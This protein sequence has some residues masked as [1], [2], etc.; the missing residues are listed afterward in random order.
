MIFLYSRV[1]KQVGHMWPAMLFYVGHD[2]FAISVLPS[3][4]LHDKLSQFFVFL[5][6]DLRQ[7]SQTH[8]T[9][10]KCGHKWP[11]DHYEG[12]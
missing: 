5:D 12:K 2:T 11:Y 7:G 4:I 9:R 10:A 1:V 6:H 3:A 8:D